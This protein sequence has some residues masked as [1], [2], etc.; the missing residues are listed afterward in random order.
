MKE[1]TF[2]SFLFLAMNVAGQ[3]DLRIVEDS[4]TALQS[5]IGQSKSDEERLKASTLVD[6]LLLDIFNQQGIWDYPFEKV[7]GMGILTSPDEAF[8]I[9][10]WNVPKNDRS[11]IYHCYILLAP[12]EEELPKVIELK[13]I[14][15]EPSR[16]EMRNLDEEEWLGCLYY[17]I[18]PVY[19]KRAIDHYVLLGWDG[20]NRITK[21]KIIEALSF[22]NGSPQ[23]GKA[24]FK[25]D[26]GVKKR[27]VFE[28]S[29]EVSMSCR[30]QEKHK[31]LVFDHLAPRS[32]G[33]EGNPAF[34]GPDL[35]F[36]AF[37][38]KKGRW[39][40]VENVDVRQERKRSKRP[41]KDPRPR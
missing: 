6:S 24:V 13:Q 39:E 14:K 38:L 19:K 22:R 31:R 21:R 5:R 40:F 37:E 26:K 20:H 18:I 23:F 7:E 28:Y 16:I 32:A 17:D 12:E 8:R 29:T 33:L 2:I 41:Y 3:L 35:T 27:V 10:N 1:L 9:F 4:L 34:Y 30:Y 15:N 11:H 25:M 36:D